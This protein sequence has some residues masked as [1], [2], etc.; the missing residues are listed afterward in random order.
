MTTGTWFL[1]WL[2][3][4]SVLASAMRSADKK[5]ATTSVAVLM[6][7]WVAITY[8]FGAKL[9]WPHSWPHFSCSLTFGGN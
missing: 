9:M 4:Q 7:L 6:I 8:W 3:A 2:L 5:G 1:V